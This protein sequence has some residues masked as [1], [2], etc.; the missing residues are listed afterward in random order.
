MHSSIGKMQ[1][2]YC[3]VMKYPNLPVTTQS[4]STCLCSDNCAVHLIFWCGHWVIPGVTPQSSEEC[5]WGRFASHCLKFKIHF[6]FP[7]QWEMLVINHLC[8]QLPWLIADSQPDQSNYMSILQTSASI[9][10]SLTC[11]LLFRRTAFIGKIGFA[12]DAV[13]LI[14]YKVYLWQESWICNQGLC[15]GL[16]HLVK[17]SSCRCS[18]RQSQMATRQ[19]NA[20]T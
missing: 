13:F 6:A 10:M 2:W 14:Q 3:T 8:H 18:L 9:G 1:Q 16:T 17:Y 7:V 19:R 11:W 5:C 12:L 4:F 20:Q 15:L